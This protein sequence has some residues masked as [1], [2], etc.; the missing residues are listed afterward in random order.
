M[1]NTDVATRYLQVFDKSLVPN[2]GDVPVLSLGC[3]AGLSVQTDWGGQDGLQLS[4]GFT[5]GISTDPQVFASAG[6]TGFFQWI[7]KE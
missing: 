6:N 7:A 2:A 5:Y 1:T 4:N 3:P